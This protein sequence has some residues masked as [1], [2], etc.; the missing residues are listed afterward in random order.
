MATTMLSYY[1]TDSGII[2]GLGYQGEFYLVNGKKPSKK[3]NGNFYLIENET[4]I[5]TVQ[6]KTNPTSKLVGFKLRDPSLASEKY[7]LFLSLEEVGYDSYYD[8][9]EDKWNKHRD[10][11]YLYIDSYEKTEGGYKNIEFKAELIAEIKGNI[12]DPITTKYEIHN[13][14]V[15]VPKLEDISNLVQYDQFHK[16]I[17]PSFA[18]HMKPCYISADAFYKIV[19]QHIKTNLD[20]RYARINSDY[21]FCFSVEKFILTKGQYHETHGAYSDL[22][23]RK[24]KTFKIFD[25]A[26]KPYQSYHVLKS[27]KGEN[28]ADLDRK[29][30]EFLDL[31]MKSINEPTVE[32]E[33]CKGIGFIAKQFESDLLVE[34]HVK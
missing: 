18:L 4:S 21:D 5:E 34:S 28:L 26:P 6:V 24:M 19:R 25:M 31:I 14:H 30:K 2:V 23:M 32:C 8:D 33:C 16:I 11:S 27:I 12:S 10:I 29:I 7:P 9:D 22:N 20:G 15:K 1:K 17:T 13:P 3:F